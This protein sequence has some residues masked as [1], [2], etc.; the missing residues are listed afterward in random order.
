MS[1]A[2]TPYKNEQ[3]T[4]EGRGSSKPRDRRLAF[5]FV[6]T[7]VPCIACVGVYREP[8]T[9]YE[10]QQGDVTRRTTTCPPSPPLPSPPPEMTNIHAPRIWACSALVADVER[11]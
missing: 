11:Q 7:P 1:A 6:C 2:P 8:G 9:G 10:R 3:P 4:R 5:S